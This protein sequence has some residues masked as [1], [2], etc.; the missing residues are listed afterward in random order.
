[1]TFQFPAPRRRSN[2]PNREPPRLAYEQAEERLPTIIQG[3]PVES[4]E[5][6]RVAVALEILGW[7]YIYQKSY[8]G[9][10]GAPGGFKIDFLVLTPGTATPLLV[11]ST[12]WHVIRSRQ[13]LDILQAS[14]LNQIGGLGRPVEVWDFELQSI[15][16]AV[17]TLQAK[18]GRP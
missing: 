13:D 6:A 14:K 8:F 10:T 7:R 3:R 5:E 11:H 9:G 2:R 12:Y 17:R 1:M 4:K 18:L 16:Q 15:Q